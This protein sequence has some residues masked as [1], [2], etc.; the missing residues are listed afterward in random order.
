MGHLSVF[1]Y[2]ELEQATKYF[3]KKREL[4]YG[5]Y[6]KVHLGK[7]QDGRSVALNRFHESICNRVEKFMNELK[8]LSSAGHC[9]L[10]VRID[11]CRY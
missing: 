10:C 6:S 5:G 11:S 3:D 2:R 1:S 7:L 8:I 9:N 4:G